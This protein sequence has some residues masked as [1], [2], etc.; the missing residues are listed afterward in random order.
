VPVAFLSGCLA[1]PLAWV[2]PEPTPLYE[3]PPPPGE[4]QVQVPAAERALARWT[5]PPTSPWSLYSKPTLFTAFDANVSGRHGPLRARLPDVRRMPEV[6]QA[7]R[8]ATELAAAGVPPGTLWLVDLHGAASVAFGATL[9]QR[10]A[11][12]IAPVLTFNNWPD[13]DELIPAE[14]PLAALLAFPPRLPRADV[15]AIPVFLLDHW[16]L[17][18]HVA[19]VE[20]ED[21]DNRYRLY[22]GDLPT[23]NELKDHGIT[24]VVYLVASRAATVQE[25]DD[26]NTRLSDYSAAGIELYLIDLDDLEDLG[27]RHWEWAPAELDHL[28]LSVVERPLIM[29]E[30]DLYR[31]SPGGFGGVHAV[32][33]GHGSGAAFIGG[34]GGG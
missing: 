21:V 8:A 30:P 2:A 34:R 33:W 14:E 6:A 29:D 28:R 4:V 1:R 12:P 19:D 18:F 10:S 11:A 17:V 31:G 26:L 32:P 22:P 15:P 3:P 23:P 9:S 5:L 7:T 25:E 13:P 27:R 16:R 20:D 24:Q